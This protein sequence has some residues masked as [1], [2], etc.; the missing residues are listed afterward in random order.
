MPGF[1]QLPLD[2]MDPISPQKLIRFIY[3]LV[4]DSTD[5]EGKF[6]FAYFCPAEQN[7]DNTIVRVMMKTPNRRLQENN[8]FFSF[9]FTHHPHLRRFLT[10]PAHG[11][12]S[13]A[14]VAFVLPS[15]TASQHPSSTTGVT[16]LRW[17]S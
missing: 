14:A 17:A 3:I 4:A 7:H 2:G 12:E 6:L 16:C 8:N 9:S 10:P 13:A 5:P 1:S 15:I 11:L